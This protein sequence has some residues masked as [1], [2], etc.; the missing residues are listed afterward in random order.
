V[1]PKEYNTC[2]ANFSDG[3]Y[4]F[5]LKNLRHQADAEDVV[6]TS[7]ER[8]WI[9]HTSVSFEKA[10]SYLFTIAYRCMI[11]LI[12]K[13]KRIEY[14]EQLPEQEVLNMGE[15]YAVKELLEKGLK[16]LSEIQR[17]VILLRDYEGY[18]YEEIGK[19]TELKESQVKVYIFRAR[20]KLKSYIKS[21]EQTV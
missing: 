15:N 4:R 7:F 5:I 13:A 21:I 8:L 1:T 11:D 16:E 17:S 3:V 12:R 6:Q 20:Q 9:N 2:V 19:I 14:P 18:S 10:K